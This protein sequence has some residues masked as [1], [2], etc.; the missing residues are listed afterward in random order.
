VKATAWKNTARLLLPWTVSAGALIYVFGFKIDW[1][2]IPEA[3]ANANF[4]LF[5]AITVFDKIVFF[6]VWALLQAEAVQRFIEPVPRRKVVAVKGGTELVRTVNN[7]LADASFMVGVYQLVRSAGIA[8]VVAITSIPFI[9]HSAVLLIQVSLALPFLEGGFGANRDVFLTT[10]V[11]WSVVVIITVGTRLGYTG[12]LMR[13]VGLASVLDQLNRRDLMPFVLWFAVFAVFDVLIQG[14]ASRAFG[15]PIG[16]L[17]LM[18]RIP[19]MYLILIIPSLGNFGTREI[20]WA[21]LFPE[22]GSHEALYAFA[23]WTNTIFLVMH[24]IIGSL[25]L[26]RAIALLREVRAAR[27]EGE[28]V[29]RPILRDAIDS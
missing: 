6:L 17:A 9:A 10:L 2:A 4:P 5:V 20:A 24:V 18:A 1:H 26:G 19:I 23:F 14:L 7:S 12:G 28:E 22:Y 11:C 27:A 15:V 3:T 8:R 29:P 13:R 21:N 16:W 25:F